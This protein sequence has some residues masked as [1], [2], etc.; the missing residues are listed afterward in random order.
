MTSFFKTLNHFIVLLLLLYT[1]HV[2]S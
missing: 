2:S 1:D